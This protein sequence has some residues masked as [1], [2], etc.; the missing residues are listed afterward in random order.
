LPK[1]LTEKGKDVGAWIIVYD[2]DTNRFLM[3]KRSSK[4]NN[5]N[6]WNFFGGH[7]DVGES[8]RV[9]A[10]REFKEE[11]GISPKNKVSFLGKI[12]TKKRIINVF[13][14]TL[15]SDTKIPFN[16]KEHSAIKWFKPGKLPSKVNPPTKPILKNLRKLLP[17]KEKI[18][19]M[20]LELVQA[21]KRTVRER[22]QRH[23][24]REKAEKLLRS[25]WEKATLRERAKFMAK[26]QWDE[27]A[28]RWKRRKEPKDAQEVFNRLREQSK[29]MERLGKRIGKKGGRKASRVRK[30]KY[31]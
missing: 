21:K 28:R 11:T 10:L 24:R 22:K 1:K 4:V 9:A 3:G 8:P 6:M 19:S 20:S 17:T 15:S 13:I 18:K 5:P 31:T 26:Y 14:T 2:P 27:T 16:R 7:V 25:P 30:I 29:R 12:V 23:L